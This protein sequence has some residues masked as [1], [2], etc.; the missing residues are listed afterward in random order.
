MS[1]R[2]AGPRTVEAILREIRAGDV[3]RAR[4]FARG[5]AFT[6]RHARMLNRAC[7]RWGAAPIA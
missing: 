7:E 4:L 6:A 5:F 2:T 3:H 1:P